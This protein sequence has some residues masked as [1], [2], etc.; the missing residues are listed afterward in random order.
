MAKLFN[1]L[2]NKMCDIMKNN[3]IK[4]SATRLFKQHELETLIPPL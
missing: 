1:Q 4:E 3:L 2:F